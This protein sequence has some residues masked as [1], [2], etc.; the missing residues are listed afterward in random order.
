VITPTNIQLPHDDLGQ[1]EGMLVRFT[2][3][4][5]VSQLEFLGDRGEV[6]LS[7]G[8]LELP[9]NRYRPGTPEALAMAAANAKNQ[10]ILDDGIFVADR[11]SLPGRRWFAALGLH[12]QQSDG[13]SGLR[14]QG[15]R[16]CR[17]QAAGARTGILGRQSARRTASHGRR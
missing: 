5:T 13:G 4:L 7:S 2:N 1:V 12:R 14:R 6:T 15:R 8:R 10:I 16:R 11:D 3:A 9:T 17:L